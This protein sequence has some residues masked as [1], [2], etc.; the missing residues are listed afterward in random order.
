M[1][2]LR[3]AKTPALACECQS[4]AAAGACNLRIVPNSTDVREV[5]NHNEIQQLAVGERLQQLFFPHLTKVDAHTHGDGYHVHPAAPGR[6]AHFSQL[7]DEL[8]PHGLAA[9]LSLA[10]GGDA[11][12]VTASL[13]REHL[14]Q[15][16]RDGVVD[17]EVPLNKGT[18]RL[19]STAPGRITAVEYVL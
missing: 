11:P 4:N 13:R 10:P 15:L 18:F 9:R 5:S 1:S 17:I 6:V 7:H 14:T 16:V 19:H 3:K 8:E 12:A 2:R